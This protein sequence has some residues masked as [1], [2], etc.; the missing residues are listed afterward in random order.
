MKMVAEYLENSIK[1]EKMAAEE[2]GPKLK[3]NLQSKLRQLAGERAK[4]YNLM[5]ES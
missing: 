3:A 1:F 2:K 5:R 4:Q